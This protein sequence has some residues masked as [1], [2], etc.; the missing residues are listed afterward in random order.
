MSMLR[1]KHT[2]EQ[3]TIMDRDENLIPVRGRIYGGSP[4]LSSA[5][6]SDVSHM[7]TE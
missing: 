3:T 2:E 6:K 5:C 4:F 1:S 7:T